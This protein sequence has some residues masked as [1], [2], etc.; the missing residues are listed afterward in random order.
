[1]LC[2]G[3]EVSTDTKERDTGSTSINQLRIPSPSVPMFV[4]LSV[5]VS[6]VRGEDVDLKKST[7][8][9]TNVH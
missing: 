3:V 5:E 6:R 7:D 9:A 1:M 2:G 8:R 4:C